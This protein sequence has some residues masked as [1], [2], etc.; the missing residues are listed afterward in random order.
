MP[1]TQK[2]GGGM[3]QE[4]RRKRDHTGAGVHTEGLWEK[5]AFGLDGKRVELGNK[6]S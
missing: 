4:Y 2:V 1:N 3:L 6:A 5:W